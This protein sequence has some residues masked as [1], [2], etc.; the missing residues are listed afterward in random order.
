VKPKSGVFCFL[1]SE[2]RE[3]TALEMPDRENTFV[4][5]AENNMEYVIEAYDTEEMKSWLSTIKYSMRAHHEAERPGSQNQ[6]TSGS[7][8][9]DNGDDALLTSPTSGVIHNAPSLPPR[10]LQQSRDNPIRS[11]SNNSKCSV[12]IVAEAEGRAI[13]IIL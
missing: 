13:T 2:A 5:K 3:T 10:L 7:L 4:L 9:G 8:T 11:N 1:I 12:V 6:N